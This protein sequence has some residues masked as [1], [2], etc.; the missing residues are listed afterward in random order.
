MRFRVIRDTHRGALRLGGHRQRARGTLPLWAGTPR[1]TRRERT[2]GR[3]PALR[4]LPPAWPQGPSKLPV[5]TDRSSS[6]TDGQKSRR[7]YGM[8][9]KGFGKGAGQVGAGVSKAQGPVHRNAAS[10]VAQAGMLWTEQGA[11]EPRGSPPQ[12]TVRR[13]S[14]GSKGCSR[15]QDLCTVSL[16]SRETPP[17]GS[18]SGT[19][20][21]RAG[22]G[23]PWVRSRLLTSLIWTA[24]GTH[25]SAPAGA[26]RAAG[27]A[28]W[29]KHEL[30]RRDVDVHTCGHS[31]GVPKAKGEQLTWLLGP[32]VHSS[33][34]LGGGGTGYAWQGRGV[35]SVAKTTRA[36]IVD[37][38][39]T[40]P[41]TPPQTLAH[42]YPPPLS[43]K[44]PLCVPHLPGKGL[45]E[46]L[47]SLALHQG[48][49]CMPQLCPLAHS[50]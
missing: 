47:T 41:N 45:A 8:S 11:R 40:P 19:G 50:V 31:V 20:H 23:Q 29:F 48:Q 46:T 1:G 34:F 25:R 15:T 13:L 30:G 27:P 7:P 39:H 33:V 22:A 6:G 9:T 44:V 37:S 17:R 28:P 26:L 10:S 16:P 36:K 2:Q 5:S 32:Q 14:P 49:G 38:G 42:K 35:S 24:A 4:A 18:V 3:C 12:V 21:L 43:S